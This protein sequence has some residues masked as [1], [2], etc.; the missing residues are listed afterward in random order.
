MA[1]GVTY[2]EIRECYQ[3]STSLNKDVYIGTT[4]LI[5]S[6]FSYTDMEPGSSHTITPRHFVD[7]LKVLELGG[8]GSRS[9]PNG[10]PED[11]HPRPYQ[12][13]YD[14]KYYTKDAPPPPPPAKQAP[15]GLKVPQGRFNPPKISPTNSY[16]SVNSSASAATTGKDEKKKKKGRLFGF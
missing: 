13:Y 9:L 2:S 12:E 8:V 11:N 16:S 1:G 3:L 10:I 6:F 15:A 7:D 4:P 14:R 5:F